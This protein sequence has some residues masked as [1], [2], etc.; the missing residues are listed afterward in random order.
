[1]APLVDTFWRHIDQRISAKPH[2]RNDLQR[3][4]RRL[5]K[6]RNKNTYTNW[7]KATRLPGDARPDVRLSDLE[8]VATALNVPPSALVATFADKPRGSELQLDLPF[9]P[10]VHRISVEFEATDARLLLHISRSNQ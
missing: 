3:E 2:A 6:G 8:D 7:F 1:M 9:G 5:N 10:D 4:L